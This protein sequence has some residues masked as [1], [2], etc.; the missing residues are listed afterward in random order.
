MWSRMTTGL[1]YMF[2]SPGILIS[3]EIHVWDDKMITQTHIRCYG[4]VCAATQS[5]R[6][7]EPLERL[8]F[9]Y[10]P[11]PC[12]GRK[13]FSWTLPSNGF[14]SGP[15]VLTT[16]NTFRSPSLASWQTQHGDPTTASGDNAGKGTG[17]Y[18]I[19]RSRHLLVQRQALGRPHSKP[20]RK[21]IKKHHNS[22]IP[23]IINPFS[24]MTKNPK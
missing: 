20:L 3:L 14:R 4:R 13:G 5:C 10:T 23:Q 21:H 22:S 11:S 9:W 18:G 8:G 2:W 12:W 24:H 19:P 7:G 1:V 15:G 6:T 17:S 16:I